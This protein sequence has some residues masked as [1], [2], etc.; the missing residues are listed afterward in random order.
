MKKTSRIPGK[1]SII[2]SGEKPASN[3]SDL[4]LL[5][6]NSISILFYQLT[7]PDQTEK[8]LPNM[9]N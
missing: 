6:K 2:F 9:E 4:E 1:G 3:K 7:F 8:S 5:P